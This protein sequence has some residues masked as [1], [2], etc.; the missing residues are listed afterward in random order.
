MIKNHE[1]LNKISMNHK[2]QINNLKII[3]VMNKIIVKINNFNY[4]MIRNQILLM[5]KI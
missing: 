2:I 4:N 3:N 5:N 1:F